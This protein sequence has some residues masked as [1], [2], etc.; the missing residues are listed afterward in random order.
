MDCDRVGRGASYAA[1]PR[2]RHSVSRSRSCAFACI[3]PADRLCIAAVARMD[4]RGRTTGWPRLCR[5]RIET[6]ARGGK[7]C[8]K[9]WLRRVA[10]RPRRRRRSRP[11]S[12]TLVYAVVPP[13][14]MPMIGRAADAAGRRPALDAARRH[15]ADPADRRAVLG[16]R[17]ASAFITAWISTR[18]RWCFRQGGDGGPN[19]G[20]STIA[21]QIA[22]NLY[23]WP[24]PTLLR[25]PLEIPLALWID[26]VWSQAAGDRG[27]SQHRRM[28]RRLVWRR[29]SGPELFRQAGL[30]A[31]GARVIACSPSRCRTRSSAMRAIRRSG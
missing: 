4:V 7:R 28:G 19:R 14:S 2:R 20:A 23:L 10:P 11:S 26:L 17:A 5:R 22:K 12:L 24:L 31:D 8:A 27:L 29:G 9:G 13:I 6:Q 21:M 3:R 25:K 30:G 16:G 18:S 15:R 1:R